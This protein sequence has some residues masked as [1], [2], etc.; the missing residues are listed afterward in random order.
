MNVSY[1]RMSAFFARMSPREC[2]LSLCLVA[3]LASGWAV[4]AHDQQIES[5]AAAQVARM[6]NDR[7]TQRWRSLA[8]IGFRLRVSRAA[9]AVRTLSLR[10]PSVHIAA[11]RAQDMLREMA[12]RAGLTN[13]STSA[14]P[15]LQNAGGM[16]SIVVRLQ[17]DYDKSRFVALVQDMSM[18]GP[19]FSPIAIEVNQTDARPRFEMMVQVIWVADG[20]RK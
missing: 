20:A 14:E 8:D 10:D 5:L 17:G 15:P 13:A 16:Q 18:S 1:A 6:A 2:A 12:R 19:G 9:E 11:I 3:A 7:A 4:S